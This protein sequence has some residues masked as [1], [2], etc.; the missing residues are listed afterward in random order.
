V[1]SLIVPPIAALIKPVLCGNF[2]WHQAG[3]TSVS[4]EFVNAL[5]VGCGNFLRVKGGAAAKH[6]LHAFG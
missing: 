2:V 3:E 4:G 6:G 1:I 5:F